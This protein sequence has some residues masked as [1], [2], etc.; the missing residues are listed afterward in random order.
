MSKSIKLKNNTYWDTKGIAH[1]N[2]L[3][4]D[5]LYPVGSIY[6]S[7]NNTSPA[8]LFGG[9]WTQISGRFLYCTTTSKTTGGASTHTHTQ[10][11]TGTASGNTGA[12][13]LTENQIPSHKH[14]FNWSQHSNQYS[15]STNGNSNGQSFANLTDEGHSLTAQWCYDGNERSGY[16]SAT[17]GGGSHTHTLNS[18]THTNPTTASASSLPPYFTVYCWYRTA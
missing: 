6:M 15:A 2:K 18:H 16:T 12:T 17:G 8:T 13:T 9:T 14:Y 10:G 4:S 11:A 7:V 5:I 1:N 3:L